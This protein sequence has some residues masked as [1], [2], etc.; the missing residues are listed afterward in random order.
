MSETTLSKVGNSAAVL[1]PKGLRAKACLELGE[2][3]R[4]ESPRKGVVVITA[5]IEDD[6][7]RLS[8]LERVESRI[9]AR[10]AS[11]EPWPEEMTA[12]DLLTRGKELRTDELA[13][14]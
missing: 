2:P 13:S 9:K 14:L 4:L 7:D 5:L 10:Q 11:T 3:V 6:G 12:S 8:R 1:L